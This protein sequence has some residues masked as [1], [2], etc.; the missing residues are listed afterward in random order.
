MTTGDIA[1]AAVEPNLRDYEQARAT[2]S[3]AA[4]RAELG[5]LPGGRGLNIAHAAVDRHADGPRREMIALRWRGRH[6][7]V[8]DINYGELAELTNRFANVL[9]GL[10]VGPGGTAIRA[11]SNRCWA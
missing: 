3:W 5:G 7:E 6:G 8:R 1:A 11:A 4:A 9:R 10:G 2:F